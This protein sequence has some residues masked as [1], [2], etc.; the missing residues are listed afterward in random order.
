[1]YLGK[2][3]RNFVGL[4]CSLYCIIFIGIHV[5]ALAEK[6]QNLIKKKIVYSGVALWQEVFVCLF[7][8]LQ[9]FAA[10][11]RFCLPN[12]YIEDDWGRQG[13]GRGCSSA[14]C[15]TKK[16]FAASWCAGFFASF[17]FFFNY[18][19]TN[20]PNLEFWNFHIIKR[21]RLLFDIMAPLTSINNADRVSSWSWSSLG[22]S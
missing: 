18:K 17:F 9:L 1:M 11:Y 21:K 14:V 7:A 13:E 5:C 10:L 15:R 16:L 20:K 8:L 22:A 3:N 6:F 2:K 19:T 12:Q 4:C